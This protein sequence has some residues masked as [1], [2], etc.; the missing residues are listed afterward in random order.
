MPRQR[1]KSLA[2]I[3][4]QEKRIRDYYDRKANT[5]SNN[6]DRG[7]RSLERSRQE[8]P[9]S[10]QTQNRAQRLKRSQDRLNNALNRRALATKIANT[11]RNNI[12][13]SSQYQED[14]KAEGDAKRKKESIL[15][16]HRKVSD[17]SLRTGDYALARD[18]RRREQSAH[19]KEIRANLQRMNRQYG[20]SVYRG[21]SAASNASTAAQSSVG[22]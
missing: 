14:E 9:N 6:V 16:E 21:Q 2:E 4:A 18:F 11:Y 22:G 19:N 5:E 13:S 15:A 8:N 1:T 7:K 10:V 12:A 17:S 3:N 20:S